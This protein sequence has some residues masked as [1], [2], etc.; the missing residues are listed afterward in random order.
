[1][2]RQPLRLYQGN[3]CWKPHI[4][5]LAWCHRGLFWLKSLGRRQMVMAHTG[6]MKRIYNC[7][8]WIH[9]HCGIVMMHCMSNEAGLVCKWMFVKKTISSKNTQFLHTKKRKQQ[10]TNNQKTCR[11]HLMVLLKQTSKQLLGWII[12][13][14]PRKYLPI[15]CD[16]E[17]Q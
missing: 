12:N 16:D 15:Q 6:G 10:I 9:T 2:P 4:C 5:V 11:L 13:E 7:Y 3:T 8:L 14:N 17:Q 1:M